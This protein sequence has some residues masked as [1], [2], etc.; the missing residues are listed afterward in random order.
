MNAKLHLLGT[1]AG[2]TDAHRTTTMV[3]FSTADEAVLVDCGGDVL[4]RAMQAGIP[5]GNISAVILTHE[6]PDHVGGWALFVEKVWLNGR[7]HPIPVYGP[8]EALDQAERTF[9]TY[10]TSGWTGL[11][12][13]IMHTVPM[14]EGFEF[15]RLGPLRF[16]STPGNHGVPSIA[17]R[18]DNVDSG[19]SV[20]YSSDTRPSEEISRL[21]SG[22]YILVHE[23]NGENPVH[24]TPE[25][26]ARIAR[27]SAC[28][29]LVLVHLP[30]GMTDEHLSDAR[31]VF[32][33]IELGEELAEYAF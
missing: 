15:L 29:R 31:T 23:A 19:Q 5:V 17:V 24:S 12:E 10:N 14:E 6:H 18:V 22:C 26:A 32:P 30:A 3:A 2:A 11:P 33:T 28:Q 9:A 21:A 16:K 13:A 4:Q 25:Q 8:A 27:E 7:R 1:G 20:C